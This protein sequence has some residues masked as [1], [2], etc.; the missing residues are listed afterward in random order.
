MVPWRKEELE[1][2]QLWGQKVFEGMG[3]GTQ[4][5]A[6]FSEVKKV[7]VVTPGVLQ[8]AT[9]PYP[10]WWSPLDPTVGLPYG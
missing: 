3:L 2:L 6:L 1:E 5:Y 4:K 10:P 9:L 7:T 8:V